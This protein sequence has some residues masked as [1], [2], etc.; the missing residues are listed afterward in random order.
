MTFIDTNVLVY[1][2]DGAPLLDQARAAVARVAADGAITIG[3]QVLREYLSV[4][5]RQQICGKPLTL[6]QA[7]ATPRRSFGGSRV[8]RMARWSGTARHVEPPLSLRGPQAHNVII[9]ATIPAHGERRLDFGRFAR[10][11]E[12]VAP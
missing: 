7:V 5:T 3:R 9:V 8:S 1:A 4:V 6:A 10:L 11:I 12:V 2:A